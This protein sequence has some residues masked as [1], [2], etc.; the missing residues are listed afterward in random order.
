MFIFY[1]TITYKLWIKKKFCI[2]VA[3]YK[4]DDIYCFPHT[5]AV[6]RSVAETSARRGG[7]DSHQKGI[8]GG[9]LATSVPEETT[10]RSGVQTATESA[11]RTGG[12]D[13]A[14]FQT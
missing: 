5:G 1:V 8:G 12:S 3:Q 13:S 7:S 10:D 14:V 2:F 11:A 4:N 6:P 9:G